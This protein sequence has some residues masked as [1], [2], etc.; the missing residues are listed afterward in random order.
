MNL[1]VRALAAEHPA[2]RLAEALQRSGTVPP[3]P[4]PVLSRVAPPSWRS[5]LLGETGQSTLNTGSTGP[6]AGFSGNGSLGTALD[7]Q[8]ILATGLRT[9]Q[10]QMEE[11]Q[12]N[13]LDNFLNAVAGRQ[14]TLR[15][16]EQRTALAALQEDIALARQ[17]NLDA[18]SPLLP[19]DP[20]QLE[21]TNLRLGIELLETQQRNTDTLTEERRLRL[22]AEENA[23]R[24]RLAELE[25]QWRLDLR[26]Q[27]QERRN[28]LA[29]LR[30]ERPRLLEQQ[31]LQEIAAQQ[32]E[33]NT[34]NLQER[35]EVRQAQR[36][37]IAEDFEPVDARLGIVLPAVRGFSGNVAAFPGSTSVTQR[38]RTSQS[39][40][41]SNLID[42]AW[43]G[44]TSDEEL[45]A[46]SAQLTPAERARQI[47]ILRQIALNDSQQWARILARR[48][49]ALQR[50][51]T[52]TAVR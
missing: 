36:V 35:R 12:E 31:R 21:M 47:R 43:A 3:A 29:R 26:S 51:S 18:L 24:A 32:R 38:V 7:Q 9:L 34:Q 49:A 6:I 39:G 4:D 23:L 2:W 48:N 19:E 44:S 17:V 46:W 8:T 30:E 11:R 41:P 37:R 40:V 27:A 14:T 1:N 22:V 28:L 5:L 42:A 50:T 25:R 10:E 52:T 33:L 15:S 13:S 45:R 16:Q 20:V